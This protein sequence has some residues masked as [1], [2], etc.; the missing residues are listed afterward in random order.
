M[1]GVLGALAR[2]SHDEVGWHDVARVRI[3]SLN[4]ARE[5]PAGACAALTHA[6]ATTLA[7][8]ARAAGGGATRLVLHTAP[9]LAEV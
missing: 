4:N 9:D 5:S 6:E 2:L 1:R 8:R 7:E 3:G